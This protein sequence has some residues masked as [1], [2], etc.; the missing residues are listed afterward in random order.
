MARCIAG[1][2]RWSRRCG[3]LADSIATLRVMDEIRRQFGI[4]FPGEG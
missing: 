1:G 4:V 2:P 3:P